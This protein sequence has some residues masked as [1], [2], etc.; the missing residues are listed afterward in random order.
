MHNCKA[1]ALCPTDEGTRLT[2]HDVRMAAAGQLEVANAKWATVAE[3]IDA[4]GSC[5]H[6]CAS[7]QT[8]KP[9]VHADISGPEDGQRLVVSRHRQ[10]QVRQAAAK[11][12]VVA[13]SQAAAKVLPGSAAVSRKL[14]PAQLEFLKRSKPSM[15]LFGSGR[16]SA[17]GAVLHTGQVRQHQTQVE[18]GATE[19]APEAGTRQHGHRLASL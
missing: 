5:C 9:S 17:V 14:P 6:A 16:P 18:A 8:A 15:L 10:Q 19:K 4:Q 1:A 13:L 11:P 3:V 2:P 7:P 12:K